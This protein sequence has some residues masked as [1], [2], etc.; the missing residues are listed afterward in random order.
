MIGVSTFLIGIT[1]RFAWLNYIF[2]CYNFVIVYLGDMLDFPDIL[3]DLTPFG[4][5]VSYPLEE[6]TW[7]ASILMTVLFIL[8]S[9]AGF[10][11]YRK[12]DLMN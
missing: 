6:I 10:I 7:G 2:L 1:P 11:G 4:N 9:A 12:R 8:L 3:G 5:V